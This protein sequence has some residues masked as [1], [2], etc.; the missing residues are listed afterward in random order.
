MNKVISV[1][2]LAIIAAFMA[3]V[4]VSQWELYTQFMQGLGQEPNALGFV[5]WVLSR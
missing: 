3:L 2:A 5:G 1:I 4:L